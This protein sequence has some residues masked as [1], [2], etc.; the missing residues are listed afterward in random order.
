MMSKRHYK[1]TL[2]RPALE[3]KTLVWIIHLFKTRSK[4]E[5]ED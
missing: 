3:W 5:V 1:P 4:A 2:S